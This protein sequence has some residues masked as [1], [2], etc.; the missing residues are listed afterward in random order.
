[1]PERGSDI[2]H[3]SAQAEDWIRWVRTPGHDAFWAYRSAF[4]AFLGR[5]EG[6][7]LEVGCGEGR[8]SRLMAELG[9]AVIAADPVRAFLDAARTEEPGLTYLEA[10]ATD[11]PL[12][13]QCVDLV[14]MYNMLM[15][16]EAPAEAVAEALRVLRPGGR[17][18]VGVVH[19]F[20]D[21]LLAHQQTGAFEGQGSYFEDRAMDAQVDER[22]GLKMHFKGWNRSLSTYTS[23]LT[24]AGAR[25]V[26][27]EEPRPDPT[28]E[29][30]DGSQWQRLPLFLWIES[31]KP[32]VDCAA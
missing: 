5:G 19:P 20:A 9:Y 10:A 11:L 29:W 7:A 15:D 3:W 22:N 23:L 16:V 13:S 6:P 12:P 8:V 25:L 1:M 31:V 30:S 28:Q 32:S 17:L 27:L 4:A 21:L 14:V 24:G 2:A 18:V 26:R